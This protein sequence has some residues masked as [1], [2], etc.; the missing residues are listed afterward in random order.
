MP[1]KLPK[2]TAEELD[3]KK[4]IAELKTIKK[5]LHKEL[6]TKYSEREIRVHEYS[7]RFEDAL[8]SVINL[9]CA[10]DEFEAQWDNIKI[11]DNYLFTDFK[12][13]FEADE[14]GEINKSLCRTVLGEDTL[15]DFLDTIH[16]LRDS[17]LDV[18]GRI[19]YPSDKESK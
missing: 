13:D 14:R 9:Q 18:A 10:L 19:V 16:T 3:L 1:K 2:P 6:R 12:E 15:Y 7:K 5:Q 4:A 8:D 11:L 17:L